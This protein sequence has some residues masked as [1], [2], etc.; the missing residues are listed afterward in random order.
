[1]EH[2]LVHWGYL[3][4]FVVCVVSSLGIPVGSE[5]VTG[6][7]GALASGKLT[8]EHDH[9]SLGVVIGVG[10]AAE[11]VGSTA[12]Y[13]VG[14]FGG[15]PLVDRLGKYVLLTHRD[16]DRAEDW[17]ARR[18]E[19]FV[20]F[21]RCIPLLRS[22]V[23]LA[24]GLGEM[25]Y[26]KFVAFTIVGSAI[27][28]SALAGIGYSLGAS[29]HHVLKD[30]DYAG[31]VAAFLAVLAVVVI[32]L[33][34]LRAVRSE[35]DSAR[36]LHGRRLVGPARPAESRAVHGQPE[37]GW[38]GPEEAAPR[39]PVPPRPSVV[40]PG[41]VVARRPPETPSRPFPLQPQPPVPP[42][43]PGQR[44]ESDPIED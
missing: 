38:H 2:F 8:S 15:R 10:V 26:A 43:G 20:L 9:L 19:P 33:H 24:A 5:I 41:P 28:V 40:A 21:G 1:M 35:H 25:A 11:L 30:F 36:A 37:Q 12:G 16:L 32:F 27:F 42:Q 34:R 14:R 23:S 3:A 13:L 39:R 29:W 7:A 4:L 18:G 44:Y 31:Y 22:F 17:F 6:Y